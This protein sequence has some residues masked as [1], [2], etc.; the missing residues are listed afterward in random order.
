MQ[1]TLLTTAI[2][3]L[4]SS[5][6]GLPSPQ[7]ASLNCYS[8]CSTSCIQAGNIRGGLCSSEGTCTCLTNTKRDLNLRDQISCFETCSTDCENAGNIR[9]GLCSS[10]GVCTCLTGEKDKR[11]SAEVQCYETCSTDC[12]NAGNIRGGLCSA[13]G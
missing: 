2:L 13:D 7:S 5:I 10:D 12:E 6:S 8:T 3:A 4:T 9:G 11:Q 1:Y